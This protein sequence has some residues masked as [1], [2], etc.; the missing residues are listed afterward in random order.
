MRERFRQVSCFPVELLQPELS[1]CLVLLALDWFTKW[2]FEMICS[3]RFDS[4]YRIDRT[5]YKH[6]NIQINMVE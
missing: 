5:I 6:L 2:G 1:G 3:K 4:L